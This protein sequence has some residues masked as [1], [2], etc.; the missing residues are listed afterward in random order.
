MRDFIEEG[1]V[2][3]AVQPLY[4]AGIRRNMHGMMR[5]EIKPTKEWAEASIQRYKGL[6]R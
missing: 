3:I 5:R 1:H 6:G 4:L 2:Y